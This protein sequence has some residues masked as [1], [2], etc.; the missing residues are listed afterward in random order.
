MRLEKVAQSL[1]KDLIFTFEASSCF[2]VPLIV[3]MDSNSIKVHAL[4]DSGTS[5]CFI[6]K[7]FAGRHKL[8]LITKKHPIPIEVL[9][10]RPK[11]SGDVI[12]ETILLDL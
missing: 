1:I 11:V 8:P 10:E 6:D 7:Y 5:A 4:L 2:T 12:H 3:E 9:D